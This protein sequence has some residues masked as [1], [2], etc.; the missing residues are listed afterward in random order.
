MVTRREIV[1]KLR[2]GLLRPNAPVIL[3]REM[4]RTILEKYEGIAK[5]DIRNRDTEKR[6]DYMRTYMKNYQRDRRKKKQ[7][8]SA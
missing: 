8:I 5:A 4:A 2:D 3:D 7:E 6:R 1:A